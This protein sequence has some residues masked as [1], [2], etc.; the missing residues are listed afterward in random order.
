[1]KIGIVCYPTFGGSGVVATELGK[2]LADEGHQVHFITYSQ[3][4]R[5]DFF[6][7][8]LFYHEVSVRD[9]P[10]F[11]YAPYESALAS[12]L[13][14]VVRFEKLDILH[15]HYAIPHASAAFMAKQILETYGIYIPFVTT[16]H[17][18]DITLVGKDPT[19]KPV[20]T[21]SI[22]K[23]DGV[24]TVSQNLKEDTEKHFEITNEI[25]VIPNF[26]D[27]NR[28]SLKPKDHFKKAIAPNNERI[29]IHT[30]NFRKVKRTGDV[31][32][33]FEKIQKKIPSKLLMV[34]DGPERAYNEQLCRELG[35]CEHVRFLGKQDAIEEILSVSDLFLMPSESES[36]GLAALEAMACKV[37]AITS[38]AGGLPELNIDGFCGFMS[39]VGDIEDMAAKGIQIL[40]N[41][42]VL[43]RFKENAFI[44]AQD[45][46]LKKILPVYIDYYNQV[47]EEAHK[48]KTV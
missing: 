8:N 10:L 11:D 26:I 32:R 27:F 45:F 44:R 17:G 22:N 14:D 5:L 21:F 4:A 6:S 35:I 30:S 28:F 48:L 36:F 37:P 13:V 39:N 7:A 1:M 19:Y 38:N 20:V 47:I 34:G 46:D 40:E 9:Y 33:T 24:T 3:P 29:L 43:Q 42:E 23:S 41:D 18:T 2:A 12:K 25:K 16:L 15:V 31:I